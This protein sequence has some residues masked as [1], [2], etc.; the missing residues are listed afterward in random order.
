MRQSFVMTLIIALWALGATA[1][2][3]YLNRYANAPGDPGTPVDRWPAATSLPLAKQGATLVMFVHPRCSCSQASLA[4][5]NRLTTRLAGK[6]MPVVVVTRPPGMKGEVADGELAA[7]AREIRAVS[8][9]TDAD[10]VEARRFGS[11]TSGHTLLFDAAG[12]RLFSGGI[13]ASRGHEGDNAGAQ[14]IRKLVEDGRDADR[15]SA[16]VFGCS[17]FDR[18]LAVLANNR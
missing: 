6:V 13:T 14:A 1:G 9:L 8:V 5:L 17:L 11:A 12:R 10:G 18:A 16:P 15:A 4:E 3:A 2:L 7:K